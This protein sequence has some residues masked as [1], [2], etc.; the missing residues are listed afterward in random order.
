MQP[1]IKRNDL[2]YPDLCYRIVGIL[3]EVFK[4]LGPGYQEKHYQSGVRA[5]ASVSNA[6]GRKN[7]EMFFRFFD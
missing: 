3:F 2:I 6:A 4:E 7:R 1:K 5:S